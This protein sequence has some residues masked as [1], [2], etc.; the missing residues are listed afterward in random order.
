MDGAHWMAS[1][2]QAARAQLEI[3]TQNLANV[4]TDGFRKA[5]ARVAL[6]DRGLRVTAA[7][8]SEQGGIKQTGR[9]F[10]LALAGEGTFRVGDRRTR[11][12]AFTRD[13]NGFLVDDRGRKLYG[14]DGPVRVSAQA[15]VER[16]G[17]ILDGGRAVARIPL[18]AGTTIVRGALEASTV[19]AVDQTLAILTAQ[20]AFET[21][22]KTLVAIDATRQR[23][24]DDVEQL[25]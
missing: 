8:S 15:Q 19:D 12:G 18:P 23:A 11:D 10:D 1:A 9:A 20:R 16:D 2:L 13:R 4:S 21:A 24:V 3:A 5:V 17:T 14:A 25:K 7:P 6:S 22:Q